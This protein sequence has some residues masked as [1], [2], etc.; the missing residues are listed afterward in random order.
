[1]RA[2]GALIVF[3]V[4]GCKKEPEKAVCGLHAA[5]APVLLDGKRDVALSVGARLLPSDRLDAEG[6]ALLECFGGALKVLD[7]EK[8]TVGDLTESKIEAIT[9]PR[10]AIRDGALVAAPGLPPSMVVRYSDN[11][12][13]P[14]SALKGGGPSDAD[15]FKAFFT[16]NGIENLGSGPRADGPVNLPPPSQRPKVSRLHAGPPGEGGA[17]LEVEDEVVFV[18]TDDLATAALLEDHTYQLGRAVRLVLPDG[19]EATLVKDGV[20]IE[21][22][23]PMDLSLR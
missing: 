3:A 21:L 8:V 13:T 4:A 20:R 18:E 22:D 16:P 5:S 2:L 1:M 6:F 23:G 9:F 15:Y 10:F 11:R 14:T 17:Q 19:A 7:D 12:F